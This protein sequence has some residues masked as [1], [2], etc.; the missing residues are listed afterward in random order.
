M[1]GLITDVAADIHIT[2][3]RNRDVA[4]KDQPVWSRWEVLRGTP[5][6]G[7]YNDARGEEKVCWVVT[8]RT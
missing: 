2:G 6:H 5:Q 1:Q 8:S 3:W 4:L 7:L